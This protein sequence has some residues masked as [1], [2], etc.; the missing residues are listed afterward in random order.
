SN[1]LSVILKRWRKP[2]HSQ[3]SHKSLPESAKDLIDRFT[4][5]A[6][7]EISTAE[8][9][10]LD[11]L[12]WSTSDSLSKRNLSSVRMDQLEAEMWDRAPVTWMYLASLATSSKQQK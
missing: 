3:N 8:L 4:L 12:L 10:C 7:Q 5:E 2:P 1:L 11:P 6:V 9:L